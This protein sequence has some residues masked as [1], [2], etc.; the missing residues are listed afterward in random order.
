MESGRLCDL[1]NALMEFKLL[2]GW[3]SMN[4]FSLII[5]G[6]NGVLAFPLYVTVVKRQL[7]IC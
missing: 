2:F 5:V 3:L 7:S 6:V 4:S 1:G